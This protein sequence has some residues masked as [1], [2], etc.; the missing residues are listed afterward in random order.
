[1]LNMKEKNDEQ[2]TV[3]DNIKENAGIKLIDKTESCQTSKNIT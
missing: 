1:M 3:R 2:S